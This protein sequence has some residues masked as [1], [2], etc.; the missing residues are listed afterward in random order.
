MKTKHLKRSEALERR[1]ADLS[2]LNDLLQTYQT[3]L[4]DGHEDYVRY[5]RYVV[6][7]PG[8]PN[9]ERAK[10]LLG[11]DNVIV[12]PGDQAT[13][14]FARKLFAAT[15]DIANLKIKLEGYHG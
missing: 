2:A 3:L 6:L 7:V 9:D 1:E 10:F 5:H 8:T 4:H 15:R 12:V 14:F 11:N 13:A